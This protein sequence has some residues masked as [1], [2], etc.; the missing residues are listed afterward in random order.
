VL[1]E[2]FNIQNS[3]K[4]L[5]LI[6]QKDQYSIFLNQT[7]WT[8]PK[9]PARLGSPS[10]RDNGTDFL[11]EQAFIQN[12]AQKS[13]IGFHIQ[14]ITQGCIHGPVLEPLITKPSFPTYQDSKD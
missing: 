14:E 12:A 10:I 13:V 4:V 2:R 5:E 6:C 8:H 7:N 3:K 1:T 9:S 11:R